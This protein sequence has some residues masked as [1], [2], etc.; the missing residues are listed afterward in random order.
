[1]KVL[2]SGMPPEDMWSG[3]F[4]PDET[5]RRLGLGE[6]MHDAA[7]FG[8]GYGTFAIPAAKIVRG[9]L[10][11]IDIEEAMIDTARQKATRDGIG[12]I[13]FHL[14][15][16]MANGSGL[17]SGTID[18]VML[19]NILHAEH[20]L[21]LLGEAWRILK[22]GGTAAIMH[23]IYDASTPRGPSLDVRPRPEQC[24]AWGTEV[25]FAATQPII[26][27][28]PYHYGVILMKQ[29]NA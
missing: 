11:A 28:P 22:P 29:K 3:F 23:W 8:C 24:I 25:G 15:D 6:T 27:L 20:P 4:D 10:H 12:N 14:R 2:D 18:F 7:D 26:A 9:T 17:P 19:F 16:F 1:M 13:A 5:L 21:D